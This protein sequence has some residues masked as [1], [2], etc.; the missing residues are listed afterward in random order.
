MKNDYNVTVVVLTYNPVWKKLRATL[1][2]IVEQQNVHVQIVITDDGSKNNYFDEVE[3][4]FKEIRFRDFKLVSNEKNE[5]TVKNF[6]RGI[7]ASDAEYIK[8]I[9]PGDLLYDRLTLAKWLSFTIEKRADITFCDA[10]FYNI[11]NGSLNIIKN[12]HNP[13]N[14]SIYT[15]PSS[16]HDKVINY[17]IFEDTIS[18]AT[19]LARKKV[20]LHYIA[21]LVQRVIYVE[22][23][24]IRLAVLDKKNIVYYPQNGIWYEFD[25][26]GITTSGDVDWYERT[27]KDFI[28]MDKI[29]NEKW[30]K[31]DE[32][33]QKWLLEYYTFNKRGN[34]SWW[35]K[36][37]RY[38][39]HPKWF[40]FW[41]Y[42]S[43]CKTYS[44]VDVDRTFI[45]SCFGKDC[46]EAD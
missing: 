29:C 31:H 14:M 45:C 4:F 12:A 39:R 32:T 15:K 16:Y 11:K 38:V 26:G 1:K 46:K 5:G 40:Y 41:V 28:E 18:G 7:V 9:S 27:R 3:L 2:S 33:V 43:F 25:D 17:I 19:I 13:N 36:F 44:P 24:F 34:I 21:F 42:R 30:D 23:Y 22:D 20:L 37:K 35:S 8:C 6:Y 10:V